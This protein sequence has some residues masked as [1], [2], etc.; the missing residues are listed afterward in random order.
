MYLKATGSSSYTLSSTTYTA[1]NTNHLAA[2]INNT[3]KPL[4]AKLCDYTFADKVLETNAQ[5]FFDT[6]A[7]YN[8]YV[9]DTATALGHRQTAQDNINY[10]Q[11][12]VNQRQ[13]ELDT[14]NQQ[15]ATLTQQKSDLDTLKNI[16]AQLQTLY[17]RVKT[18][19]DQLQ[20]HITSHGAITQEIANLVAQAQSLETEIANLEIVI[21]ET[22]GNVLELENQVTSTSENLTVTN[23]SLAAAEQALLT[24]LSSIA[25][26]IPKD[27]FSR[28]GTIL[29]PSSEALR[30]F[31]DGFRTGKNARIIA[32]LPVKWMIQYYHDGTNNLSTNIYP[33]TASVQYTVNGRAYCTDGQA[34]NNFTHKELV[35]GYLEETL[36]KLNTCIALLNHYPAGSSTGIENF[37]TAL[38]AQIAGLQASQSTNV[39]IRNH[40]TTT[41]TFTKKTLLQ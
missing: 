30:Y 5:D 14:L 2:I 9:N 33:A 28:N 16:K 12:L 31:L 24:K 21:A 15:K 26:V 37:L 41:N 25:T 20:A 11:P 22:E 13:A 6:K 35:N 17:N 3:A 19:L 27:S 39:T 8:T 40:V 29:T 18:I 23:T 1:H 36:T 7:N 38:K 32:D 34:M 4:L 10:A